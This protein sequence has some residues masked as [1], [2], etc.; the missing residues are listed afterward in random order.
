MNRRA[1]AA[2]LISGWTAAPVAVTV[3]ARELR[4]QAQAPSGLDSSNLFI[5]ISIVLLKHGDSALASDRVNPVAPL[6]EEDIINSYMRT[7]QR[8]LASKD[9]QTKSPTP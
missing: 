1:F 5:L 3:L 9:A 8:R 2:R 4:G 7:Q 6:V